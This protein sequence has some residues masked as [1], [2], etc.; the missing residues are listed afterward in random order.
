MNP[1]LL[2]TELEILPRVTRIAPRGLTGSRQAE[3]VGRGASGEK[4][5]PASVSNPLV[6][7]VSDRE[8]FYAKTGLFKARARFDTK[9]PFA[10]LS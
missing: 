5:L 4:K 9:S 1:K 6:C 10:L 2:P 8:G 3:S 7:A